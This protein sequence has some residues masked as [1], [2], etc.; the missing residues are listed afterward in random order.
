M[1]PVMEFI[2][3]TL[4][5]RGVSYCDDLVFLG[6]S[7]E[8]IQSKA[9]EIVA[10]LERFGWKISKEKSILNPT[11]QF[12]YLGW[13]LDTK[14]N[15]QNMTK[16]RRVEIMQLLSKWRRSIEHAKI[17]RI[18]WFAIEYYP[19]ERSGIKVEWQFGI[20][21]RYQKLVKDW[22]V[23]NDGL[24]SKVSFVIALDCGIITICY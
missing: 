21:L 9:V 16:T 6:E 17:V 7:K 11:Q 10:I 14:C 24:L 20:K 22:V 23:L 13:F 8:D 2:R 15:H 12:E 1:R 18:K 3:K 19:S 4:Q 5:V